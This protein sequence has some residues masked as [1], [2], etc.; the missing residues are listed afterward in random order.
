MAKTIEKD[1]NNV[2]IT[3]KRISNHSF[4]QKNK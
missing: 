3:F 2:V 4:L 1:D